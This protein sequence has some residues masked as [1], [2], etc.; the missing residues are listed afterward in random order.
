M[1]NGALT[2]G[3]TKSVFVSSGWGDGRL[4]AP[5]TGTDDNLYGHL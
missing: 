1:P 4:S 3:G 5:M 2:E